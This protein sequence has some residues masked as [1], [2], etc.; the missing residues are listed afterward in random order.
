MLISWI[1]KKII[2]CIF[3]FAGTQSLFGSQKE[4][5]KIRNPFSKS[6]KREPKK[7]HTPKL[8]LVGIVTIH[9]ESCAIIATGEEHVTVQVGQI[10]NGYCIKNVGNNVVVLQRGKKEKKLFLD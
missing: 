2:I 1:H 8:K 9:E 10:I 7:S 3:L 6:L 4:F 5:K